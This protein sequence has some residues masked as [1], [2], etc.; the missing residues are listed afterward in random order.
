MK[1]LVIL[2]IVIAAVVFAAPKIKE[3]MSSNQGSKAENRVNA[4][5]QAW[6]IGGTS[7]S[8]EAQ[9]AACQFAEGAEMCVDRD[10]V[11]AA[12]DKFTRFRNAKNL[13]RPIRDFKVLDATEN[14]D[15]ISTTVNV[16]ID[17]K[18]Y[19]MLVSEGEPI[20]WAD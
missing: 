4:M 8:L 3:L 2:A 17:G 14:S 20:R 16:E 11:G 18:K 9:T 13:Y 10:A 1:K 12:S 15:S 6:S 19:T 7:S 5:L